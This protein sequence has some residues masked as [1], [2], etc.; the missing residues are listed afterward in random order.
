[1]AGAFSELFARR[2]WSTP[3]A[4]SSRLRG[5]FAFPFA[6]AVVVSTTALACVTLGCAVEA[7]PRGSLSESIV[8][9]EDGRKEYF[10][11][12]DALVATTLAE[13]MVAL[14]PAGT[15]APGAADPASRI[16]SYGSQAGLCDG[17]PFAEQPAA[18]FCSGV[19][20]DWD[21]VLTAGHCVRQRSL[22]DTSI[23]FGYY[24]R[25]PGQLV[26]RRADVFHPVEIV[27]EVL[28]TRSEPRFDYAWLRLDRQV[29]LPRRPAPVY[30]A[31]PIL[32]EG[33][34][35]ISMGAS[36]GVPIKVD[37]G[38]CL[39]GLRP[40]FADYFTAD[41]DTSRGSSGGGAFDRQ[42][43]LLGVLS[44]GG[45]DLVTSTEAD[46]NIT[47]SVPRDSVA[48]EEFTY[49][50]RAVEALCREDPEASSLCR[51]DCEQPCEA[52]PRPELSRH[53]GC[54][55]AKHAPGGGF[56]ALAFCGAAALMLG[57]SRFARVGRRVNARA[58]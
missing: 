25:T 12:D 11:L 43:G 3:K 49:A 51:P 5:G 29:A 21:L 20:V 9:G 15:L 17:E 6:N 53:A 52:L 4:R 19:L 31:A 28:D 55:L 54:S 26:I 8:Y 35:I 57:R 46:C 10:E 34:A 16:A 30:T 48:E 27:A 41:T 32:A 42:L 47:F 36:G 23:V 18:A 7:E 24:Y 56:S 40:G 45:T 2:E 50:H 39:R 13:S 38:G 1:M 14:V 44:R 37:S 58:A 33:D 22:G